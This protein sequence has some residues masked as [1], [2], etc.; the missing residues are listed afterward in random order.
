MSDLT[1]F[2]LNECISEAARN[3]AGRKSVLRAVTISQADVAAAESFQA[4]LYDVK[5]QV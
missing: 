1:F 3:L 2:Q 4:L 5:R